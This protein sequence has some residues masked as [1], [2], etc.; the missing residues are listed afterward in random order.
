[1]T[2]LMDFMLNGRQYL[3][4]VIAI[5]TCLYIL[6]Q[7]LLKNQY[8]HFMAYDYESNLHPSDAQNS[9]SHY[10]QVLRIPGLLYFNPLFLSLI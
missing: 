8:A 6:C 3:W 5:S 9:L 4:L 10:C 1:M 7:H 2:S